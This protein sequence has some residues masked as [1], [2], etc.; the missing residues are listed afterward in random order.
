MAMAMVMEGADASVDDGG[1]AFLGMLQASKPLLL[2]LLL[3]L[4][5]ANDLVCVCGGMGHTPEELV[6]E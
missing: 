6:S 4:M 2:F 5:I 3:S 1:L